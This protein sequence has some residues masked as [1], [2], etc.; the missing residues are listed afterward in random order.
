M[1]YRTVAA[2]R[3]LKQQMSSHSQCNATKVA[4]KLSS[5]DS[6]TQM[7][8]RSHC[9]KLVHDSKWFGLQTQMCRNED[10]M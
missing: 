7:D 9:H 4:T 1:C 10:I 2:P 5:T 8:L 3:L 6:V